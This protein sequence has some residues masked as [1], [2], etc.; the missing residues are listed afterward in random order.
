MDKEYIE[1]P[2]CVSVE[3]IAENNSLRE[4]LAAAR[5]EAEKYKGLYEDMLARAKDNTPGI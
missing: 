1:L 5:Q 3:Q 4:E 2:P